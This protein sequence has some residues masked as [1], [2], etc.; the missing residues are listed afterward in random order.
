MSDWASIGCIA[1]RAAVAQ[2]REQFIEQNT[3]GKY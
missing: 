1:L 3:R 2:L